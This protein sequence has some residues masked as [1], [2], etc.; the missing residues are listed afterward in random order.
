MMDRGKAGRTV[1]AQALANPDPRSTIIHHT[2][3]PMSVPSLHSV[4]LTLV[5]ISARRIVAG[6]RPHRTPTVPPETIVRLHSTLAIA[7]RR[8]PTDRHLPP[9]TTLE[10]SPIT[11]VPRARCEIS[12]RHL[13]VVF[14]AQGTRTVRLL[15]PRL[16]ATR[17]SRG[18]AL[19]HGKRHLNLDPCSAMTIDLNSPRFRLGYRA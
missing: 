9:S 16:S 1:A 18:A 14:R 17:D 12:V 3:R 8:T 2:L 15:S 4:L 11:I 6:L 7:L 19:R 10:E 13:N 5:T